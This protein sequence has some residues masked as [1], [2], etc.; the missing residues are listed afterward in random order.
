MYFWTI[1]ILIIIILVLITWSLS[2]TKKTKET[3]IHPK[4]HFDQRKNTVTLGTSP[5][6]T[7]YK[8]FKLVIVTDENRDDVWN[9]TKNEESGMDF[10]LKLLAEQPHDGTAGTTTINLPPDEVIEPTQVQIHVL[11]NTAATEVHTPITSTTNPIRTY[12]GV[13]TQGCDPTT[14][15]T[16]PPLP[17]GLGVV[18]AS[19]MILET[20]YI[21]FQPKKGSLIT[22]TSLTPANALNSLAL[23]A[24]FGE[25]AGVDNPSINKYSSYRPIALY[26]NQIGCP[27]GNPARFCGINQSFSSPDSCPSICDQ[28]E[29]NNQ[30]DAEFLHGNFFYFGFAGQTATFTFTIDNTNIVDCGPACA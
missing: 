17:P 5:H 19:F 11:T 2:S 24:Y 3:H 8:I 18:P 7:M 15:S 6:A 14:G 25:F 16:C 27:D 13:V 1:L 10:A 29:A 23:Q 4:A 26:G 12:T 22:I 20:E 21:Y 30:T 28:G 9:I